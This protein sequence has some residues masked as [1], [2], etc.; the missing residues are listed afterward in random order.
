MQVIVRPTVLDRTTVTQS[1]REILPAEGS[2]VYRRVQVFVPQQPNVYAFI[3]PDKRFIDRD[4][5]KPIENI[6]KAAGLDRV[7]K[8]ALLP[9]GAQIV[10]HLLPNQAIWAGCDE[11]YAELG[12]L[13]EY[14]APPVAPQDVVALPAPGAPP[15]T[16]PRVP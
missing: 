7:Y 1:I 14:F 6:A 13:C 11:G 3:Y 2:A 12:L 16:G 5:G 4:T 9:S 15:G 10:F 8:G